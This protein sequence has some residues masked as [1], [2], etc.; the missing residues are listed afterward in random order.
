[1]EGNSQGGGPFSIITGYYPP[2]R[3]QDGTIRAW[4]LDATTRSKSTSELSA[5]DA[6]LGGPPVATS[7]SSAHTFYPR[8]ILCHELLKIVYTDD[9]LADLCGEEVPDDAKDK[10]MKVYICI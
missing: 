8:N 2:W 5:P 3:R 4:N 6:L 10:K 1:M 7:V 9:D